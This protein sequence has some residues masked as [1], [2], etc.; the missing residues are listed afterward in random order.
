MASKV[1]VTVQA[2]AGPVLGPFG[3]PGGVDGGTGTDADGA[4]VAVIG[5]RPTAC[6]SSTPT[7]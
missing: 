1:F 2:V 7:P 6:H 3:L 4:A 5:G